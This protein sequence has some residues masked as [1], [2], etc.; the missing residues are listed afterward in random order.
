[1][2]LT[3]YRNKLKRDRLDGA[4]AS[5]LVKQP[6]GPRITMSTFAKTHINATTS[7]LRIIAPQPLARPAATKLQ[8]SKVLHRHGV[9]QPS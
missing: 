7:S 4:T 8:R 1:M 3:L 5:K 2:E 9:R 6:F